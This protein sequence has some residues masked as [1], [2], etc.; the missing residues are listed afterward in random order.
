V[1]A[2]AAPTATFHGSVEAMLL[3]LKLGDRVVVHV[4]HYGALPELVMRTDLLAIVPKMFAD[5]LAARHAVRVWDLP[6]HGPQYT[7]RMM[8]HQSATNDPAHTWFREHVR[9]LFLRAEGV[10]GA[11]R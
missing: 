4:R 1:L 8:W 9:Q 3:R 6:G 11:S 7:V 2:V 10:A 5:A